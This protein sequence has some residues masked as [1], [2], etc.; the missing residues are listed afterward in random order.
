[1]LVGIVTHGQNLVQR[2]IKMIK[3]W[4]H[5]VIDPIFEAG[6]SVLMGCQQ[7]PWVHWWMEWAG[8]GTLLCCVHIVG[9]KNAIS[10]QLFFFRS[11]S[12]TEKCTKGEKNKWRET[13]T[14]CE[15]RCSFDGGWIIVPSRSL[16]VW[17]CAGGGITSLHVT[18]CS[19]YQ[20]IL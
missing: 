7:K 15:I 16:V 11:C 18:A 1:M 12:N 17:S 2:S 20:Y 14:N 9:T 5:S 4:Q 19:W 13:K 8:V 3:L 6:Q 10:I